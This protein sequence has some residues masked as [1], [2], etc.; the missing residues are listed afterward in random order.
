LGERKEWR[1]TLREYF[2]SH[3]LKVHEKQDSSEING[4]QKYIPDNYWF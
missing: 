2:T 1:T 4:F 3:L